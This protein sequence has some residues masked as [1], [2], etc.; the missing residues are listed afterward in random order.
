MQNRFLHHIHV[1]HPSTVQKKDC[2][3]SVLNSFF[4]LC[5]AGEC[6]LELDM[7]FQQH[8]CRIH[9]PYLRQFV[10]INKDLR[11]TVTW[12]MSICSRLL[13]SLTLHLG[14]FYEIWPTLLRFNRFHLHLSSLLSFPSFFS[15]HWKTMRPDFSKE[16]HIRTFFRNPVQIIIMRM[17]ILLLPRRRV[18]RTLSLKNAFLYAYVKLMASSIVVSSSFGSRRRKHHFFFNS[19]IPCPIFSSS[20]TA[21][22]FE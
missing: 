3:L 17:D 6:G 14:H 5:K 18:S 22:K 9:S 13:S 19:K 16:Q 4:V 15:Q 1:H 8:D 2:I 10:D 20:K 7:C 11:A 12:A 21:P